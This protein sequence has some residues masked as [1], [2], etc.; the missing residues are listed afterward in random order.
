MHFFRD[1]HGH[2]VDWL[3]ADA[4]RFLGIEIKASATPRPSLLDGLRAFDRKIRP[5]DGRLLV[6]SGNPRT[7]S[8][9]DRFVNFKDLAPTLDAWLDSGSS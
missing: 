6:Y 1:Q 5:L 4:R 7:H 3:F 9:G 8:A 2:E